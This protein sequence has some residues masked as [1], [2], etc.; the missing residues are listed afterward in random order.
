MVWELSRPKAGYQNTTIVDV[1]RNGMRLIIDRKLLRGGQ[2][3]IDFRGMVI[4]GKVQYC[5]P[6]EDRFAV[7]IRI[8]DV[9]DQVAEDA[10]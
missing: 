2:V 3:A 10:A 6:E 1:S 4:C 5:V 8:G 7:G 9:M